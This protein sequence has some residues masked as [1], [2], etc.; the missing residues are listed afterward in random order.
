VIRWSS[1][2]QFNNI[3]NTLIIKVAVLAAKTGPG[4]ALLLPRCVPERIDTNLTVMKTYRMLMGAV[5]GIAMAMTGH[6][7]NVDAEVPGDHF[8]LEGALE[9]FK[10][11]SSPE[12]FERMLNSPDEK[13][14]NLDLNGDGFTDYIRVINRQDR[15]VHTFTLQAVI[16]D[17]EFQDVAVIELEK[18][19]DGEAVLQIVGDPDVYGIETIIEPTSEVRTYAGTRTSRTVVNVWTWPVVH[20]VY[21]P[22]YTVWVS[23][24][25]WTTRPVWYRPWRPVTYVTYYD[26]WRPYRPHYAVCHT[27]RIVYAHQIYRPHRVTSVVVRER[28][29]PQIERYRTVYRDNPRDSRARRD[30][31]YVEGRRPTREATVNSRTNQRTSREPNSAVRRETTRPAESESRTKE[32]RRTQQQLNERSSPEP[33]RESAPANPGRAEELRKSPSTTSPAPERVATPER[34]RSTLNTERPPVNRRSTPDVQRSSP[35]SN[36]NGGTLERSRSSSERSVKPSTPSRRAPASGD[37]RRTSNGS[38][39]RGRQMRVQ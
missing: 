32:N 37:V 7:Q 6:A 5:M 19:G 21:R 17:N 1:P 33:R 39:D 36:S 4:F 29:R 34:N 9:L 12:E 18:K 8:S 35:P 30:R 25:G 28:Y 13:V 38:S 23:P 2:K 24:W 31:P 26:V 15:N 16:S 14:N 27:R 20:Y 10:K 11:S 22:A 3:P